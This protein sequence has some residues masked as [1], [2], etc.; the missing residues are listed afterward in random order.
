MVLTSVVFAVEENEKLS[1]LTRGILR[2]KGFGTLPNSTRNLILRL[3]LQKVTF[4]EEDILA[5]T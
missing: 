4:C 5:A 1:F 2:Y 3:D